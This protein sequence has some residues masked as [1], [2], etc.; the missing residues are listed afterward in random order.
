MYSEAKVSL[1]EVEINHELFYKIAHVNEMRPFLMSLVSH[2]NHWM[3]I[4]S[5]GGLT[6]GRKSADF[7]L[8][9]YYT[10]DK[11]YQS[12]EDTGSKSIFRIETQ[13]K[14]T[15]W[16]PFSAHL[17]PQNN[18][19]RN[20]YKN[21]FGNKIIFEEIHHELGLI[22]RYSWLSSST[23]GFVKQSEIINQSQTDYNISVLDG[24][25]NIMPYGVS[26]FLQQ[27]SSNLADAYKRTELDESSGLA[28]FAL[29]AAIVDKA[30]ACESLKA[31]VAWSCGLNVKNTLLSSLQIND[32]IQGKNLV[33]ETDV[34]GEKG[35]FLVESSFNL[36]AKNS[37]KWNL[38]ANVA[39]DHAQI[40]E[41]KQL[42][43]MHTSLHL[44]LEKDIAEGTESLAKLVASADGFQKTGNKLK[45]SRHYAN[46][47]FN[48]MRGGI[49][50]HNYLISFKDFLHYLQKSNQALFHEFGSSIALQ[51]DSTNYEDFIAFIQQFN[52]LDLL[53]LAVEYLPL[54]FSRRHGDPSRPWN[55]FSINTVD[56]VT[57]E[58]ILDYEGNWRDLFQNWEA[59]SLSFPEFTV[60][61]MYKFLNASTFE[62]YN[63]YRVNKIGFDWETIEHD[64]PWSYIGYWGDHQVIY[65]LKF[66]EFMQASQPE[67]LADLMG[68]K[69]FVFANVPY[70]IKSYSEILK[71]PK[72]TIIFNETLDKNLRQK[73]TSEGSDAALMQNEKQ[74]IHHVEFLEKILVLALSKLSN[75]IPE[76]GIWLNTQRPEWNDANNALVGNGASMVTLYYLR[77]FFQFFQDLLNNIENTQVEISTET[78]Q[79][80]E[81]IHKVLDLN[82]NKLQTSLNAAE[83]K[84]IVDALGLAGSHFRDKIYEQGFEGGYKKLSVK[85][86][87]SFLSL[88]LAYFDQSI[89]AN[90]RSDQ[91]Y[92]AYNLVKIENDEITV[93]HLDLML[94][95]QVAVLSAKYL[96]PNESLSLLDALKSSALYRKDQN[97]YLLYPN[98]ELPKFLD[99]NK[100]TLTQIESSK[101]LT[102]LSNEPHQTIIKKDSEGFYHF[103]G[104][105]QNANDLNGLL[106]AFKNQHN[107]PL[108]AQEIEEILAV[109]ESIFNHRA[110]TGRSGT[111]FAYEG[112][113][114]I[115]WHMVSKLHL[116]IQ[117]VCVDAHQSNSKIEITKALVHHYNAVGD[118]I[119]LEKSPVVYGAFPTD[120]YSHTPLHKGAQQPGMTGQVK[121][122]ILVRMKELG[123]FFENSSLKFQP[124]LVKKSEF[125][126]HPTSFKYYDVEGNLKELELPKN[127]LAFTICQTP[128]VYQ[129]ANENEI[130]VQNSSQKNGAKKSVSLGKD[131]SKAIFKRDGKTEAIW[132][133][134]NQEQIIN[135]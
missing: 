5:N 97:S 99:K 57:G 11:L 96:N 122:D 117:E 86:I 51:N 104:I 35:A 76:A 132:V 119:G 54:K 70:R 113:G 22:F 13:N 18:F 2:A 9:P 93:Q 103:N 59:L 126:S 72:D 4:A 67:V 27:T 115:Y 129:L 15:L 33:N 83:K 42:I 90:K 58:K 120:P 130:L 43:L 31:N 105:V 135:E 50:D 109:F 77:R 128:V 95:G 125:I 6:A 110:F 52:N 30:E 38:V 108:N 106:Q 44:A 88:G 34:K 134:I 10:D 121:E 26:S 56:E 102:K 63:P 81:A 131:E 107:E 98:K 111:F 123:V 64:N 40:I 45:N 84:Q 60:G 69:H 28:I 25:Q 75:F 87:V 1:E 94:E 114:S 37:K 61:M 14:T 100:L 65:L 21:H 68:K 46:V 116:A 39:L 66:L 79:L 3:F 17:K 48:I 41:L 118:G 29:S 49:F 16:E 82:Q 73:T 85:S 91:M 20:L 23:Y 7:A 80:F 24:L 62:G 101:A 71:D 47:L 124:F 55:K 133:K 127:A 12:I 8:F 92:H 32:F 78:L 36:S 74:E 89:K 112:L 53:R 19:T